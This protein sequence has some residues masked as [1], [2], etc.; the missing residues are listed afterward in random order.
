MSICAFEAHRDVRCG[1]GET[2]IVEYRQP[3]GQDFNR[4]IKL[5]EVPI[6][7]ARRRRFRPL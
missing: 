3:R 7:P 2:Y 1:N 5:P 4:P 6:G